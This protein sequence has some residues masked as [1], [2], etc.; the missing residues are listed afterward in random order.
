MPLAPT[1]D[2]QPSADPCMRRA[3]PSTSLIIATYNW[4]RALDIVLESVRAQRELP[5][6]V[7]VADDGSGEA[8]REIVTA[9][10]RQFPVPLTHVWHEDRGFRLA[11]IRNAAIRQAGG[12]YI[13]QVDGDIVLGRHFVGAHRRFARRGSYVQGSRC[14]V[15]QALTESLLSERRCHISP[16]ERG[17]RNRQNGMHIPWLVPFIRGPRDADDR[18]RGCHM[19][20]WRDDLQVVNGYD[21]GFVGWG[22]ED[23][24][25]AARLIH[26]G[27]VRRNFK[28]GAAAFHLWHPEVVARAHADNEARYDA[29]IRERRLRCRAG[30]VTLIDDGVA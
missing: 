21:E 13:V 2:V 9:H 22:R 10:Q 25:L 17:L 27:V 23:S 14:L 11:A 6:E 3:S 26:S 24:E 19:A 16:F 7:L 18:T 30:L 29:T 1:F 12:E 4:P 20:F 15:D 5:D 28:Y 8:T